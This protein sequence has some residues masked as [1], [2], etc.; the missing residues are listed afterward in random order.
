LKSI[1]CKDLSSYCSTMALPYSQPISENT[2]KNILKPKSNIKENIS[3]MGF[4]LFI[5]K[6]KERKE[7][8]TP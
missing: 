3:I 5:L 2:R 7:S 1:G 8:K 6:K 4:F